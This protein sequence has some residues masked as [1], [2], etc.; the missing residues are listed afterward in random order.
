VKDS[1]PTPEEISGIRPS[2]AFSGWRVLTLEGKTERVLEA[3]RA[4]LAEYLRSHPEVDLGEIARALYQQKDAGDCRWAGVFASGA[5][6]RMALSTQESPRAF[7]GRRLADA[8]KVAFLFS[9]LGGQYANMTREL[10]GNDPEFRRDIDLCASI[11]KRQTD[12]DLLGYLYPERAEPRLPFV[13]ADDRQAALTEE[14]RFEREHAPLVHAA[15]FSVQYSLTRL[16]ARWGVQPDAVLGYSLGESTAACV[17]GVFCLED[18]LSLVASR[19][20]MVQEFPEGA[21]LVVSL[22][23]EQI[24]PMLPN[25]VSL[26][27][28]NSP[29]VCVI[30]GSVN[31]V[32]ALEAELTA[33][34]V[35]SKRVR[36]GN[37]YHSCLIHP[38]RQRLA[39]LFET[40]PR[41]RAKIPYLSTVTGTWCG[42]DALMDSSYWAD[43]LCDAVRFDEAARQLL[44]D[45]RFI[46]VEIGPGQSL[47]SFIKRH[48][49]CRGDAMRRVFSLLT[50]TQRENSE[51]PLLL[52][53]LGRLWTAGTEI[54]WTP[55]PSGPTQP[56]LD[57]S[58]VGESRP[59]PPV[60]GLYRPA[61]KQAPLAA[62]APPPSMN[63]PR[64]KCL[65]LVNS[66]PLTRDL[67]RRLE[68]EGNDV[69]RVTAGDRFES[70]EPGEYMLDPAV[71]EHYG[72][73][74]AALRR[75]G[76]APSRIVHL[77]ALTQDDGPEFE[78]HDT[79]AELGSDSLIYVLRNLAHHS[80]AGPIDVT[81]V[82][83]HAQSVLPGDRVC[84]WKAAMVGASQAIS[85]EY[86]NMSGRLIDIV[87]A[88]ECAG[89]ALLLDRLAAELRNGG[90][91]TL[92][93]Y[94]QDSRLVRRIERELVDAQ[95]ASQLREGGVYLITGGFSDASLA[96][97]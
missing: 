46:L 83:N 27:A 62:S 78:D 14:Q 60:C 59:S 93:A 45:D 19:A 86:A 87:I 57:L 81:I 23:S 7:G 64:P 28:I 11:L 12:L 43:H 33:R 91:D 18:A 66:L 77:W 3:K 40:K 73:L 44:D 39:E 31:A 65:A 72:Q 25:D 79:Y 38:L 74:F 96:L 13:P 88:S 70:P 54:D 34:G 80:I 2:G 58:Q 76:K 41:S 1:N 82:S 68:Q 63:G 53:G 6:A 61:W 47:S 24:R 97:A 92:V 48:P 84:A 20:G 55:L 42:P 10:Y 29:T 9:G 16:L 85:L 22:S 8:P 4:G 21:M 56:L 35:D 15:I 26:A 90:R 32:Q 67:A 51:I 5:D 69:V 36:V 30:S 52:S 49:A 37:A 71:P 50:Y 17:A 94:R 95:P 75:T 89:Q